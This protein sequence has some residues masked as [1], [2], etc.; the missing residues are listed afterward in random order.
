MFFNTPLPCQRF[1]KCW[2]N[3]VTITEAFL[4]LWIVSIE[5]RPGCLCLG[6]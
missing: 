6:K 3:G 2:F 5:V 4:Y 1:W